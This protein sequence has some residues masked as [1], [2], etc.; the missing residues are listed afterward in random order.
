MKAL[1]LAALLLLWAA[2]PAGA[3]SEWTLLL[4][5]HAAGTGTSNFDTSA[6]LPLWKTWHSAF[7]TERQCQTARRDL[8]VTRG[9]LGQCVLSSDPRLAGQIPVPGWTNEPP[10]GLTYTDE[11]TDEPAGVIRYTPGRPIVATVKLNGRSSARLI[12]DTGADGSMVKP[13]LLAAA[14][15]DL[16]RPTARGAVSGLAGKVK[17]SY[18]PVDFEVAGH[19]ARVPHVAAF[20]TYEDGFAD[21]LLGRDFLD[22]FK[23][24]T[25]PAAGV[26]TLVPR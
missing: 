4:P 2:I 24:T 23:M 19:R 7:A 26:V 15:V 11:P 25:D 8:M 14:G 1:A 3:G 12:L 13:D 18:F 21:G 20:N 22:Q 5:P 17:V 6:P 9:V 16:S 10:P